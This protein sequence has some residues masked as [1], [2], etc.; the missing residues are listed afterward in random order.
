M[1]NPQGDAEMPPPGTAILPVI[2]RSR[3]LPAARYGYGTD[4][5]QSALA[6]LRRVD[7]RVMPISARY[8][9]SRTPVICVQPTAGI[10]FPPRYAAG[11]TGFRTAAAV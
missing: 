11:V 7:L 1:A 10:I 2:L 4:V 3:F 9:R 8:A 5:Y 6:S